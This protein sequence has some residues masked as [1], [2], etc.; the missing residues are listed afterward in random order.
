[1]GW[2]LG[3][4]RP[5]QACNEERRE[6]ELAAGR[7]RPGAV[8]AAPTVEELRARRPR[9]PDEMLEIRRTGR[10][11]ADRSCV[12]EPAPPGD[13]RRDEQAAS[14][15]EAAARVVAMGHPVSG[16]MQRDPEQSRGGA[17]AHGRTGRRPRRGV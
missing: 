10:E 3:R 2:R 5:E 1:M 11:R 16:E 17:G 9:Q 6:N 12:R 14:D 7:Q 8:P 13:E 4:L 15:L